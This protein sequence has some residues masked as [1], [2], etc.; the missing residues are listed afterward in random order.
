MGRRDGTQRFPT[1]QSVEGLVG[2]K[3]HPRAGKCK[4]CSGSGHLRTAGF[5]DF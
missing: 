5:K 2:V 3:I 4:G 1:E